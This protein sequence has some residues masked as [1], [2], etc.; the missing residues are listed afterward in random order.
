[1][2]SINS[3]YERT[4]GL[5][6]HN[7]LQTGTEMNELMCGLGM[8][9][10]YK[11]IGLSIGAQRTVHQ[12]NQSGELRSVGRFLVSLSYNFNQRKYLFKG[13]EEDAQ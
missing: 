7:V 13:E 2:A 6:I 11:N 10:Y 9:V 4:S 12:H 3:Y 1:M 5:Y 8:D